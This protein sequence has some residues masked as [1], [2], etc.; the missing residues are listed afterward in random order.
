MSAFLQIRELHKSFSNTHVL[1][2]ISLEID[3]GE[4]HAIIGPNG[5]GKSTLFNLITGQLR[6]T[7]GSILFQNHE[8]TTLP[9]EGRTRL[10][11]A[12]TMQASSCFPRLTLFENLLSAAQRGHGWLRTSKAVCENAESILQQIG[13]D[14]NR[15][16]LAEKISHG[17]R[18]LLEIGI[19]L[20]TRPKLLLL[21]EPMAGLSQDDRE[22]VFQLIKN[23]EGISLL[24]VEHDMESVFGLADRITVLHQGQVLTKGTAEEIKVDPR[25]Y[26]I[27]L[28]GRA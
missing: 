18:R 16:E 24:F 14:K 13:L 5:A 15:T 11:I 23:L 4:R 12:R 17:D 27:Y 22:R 7:S 21:D 9:I 2:G 3:Q 28:G 25:V 6:P 8:I 1:Q 19:A 10:G 20:A 26:E